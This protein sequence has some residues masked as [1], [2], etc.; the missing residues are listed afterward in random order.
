[1]CSIKVKEKNI[2]TMSEGVIPKH[3]RRNRKRKYESEEEKFEAIKKEIK[4]CNSSSERNHLHIMFKCLLDKKVNSI[5]TFDFVSSLLSTVGVL[6][7]ILLLVMTLVPNILPQMI[8]DVVVI[9]D[10][11]SSTV[12]GIQ[13]VYLGVGGIM[14]CLII[15]GVIS[16]EGKNLSRNN[17]VYIL[18]IF[19]EVNH[20]LDKSIE[21]KN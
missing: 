7:P 20:E 3:Y 13:S 14:I 18:E 1:M 16:H 17:V 9:E 4:S 15:Y 11:I 21:D 6:S 12:K 10:I 19:E 5:K 2:I 8:G